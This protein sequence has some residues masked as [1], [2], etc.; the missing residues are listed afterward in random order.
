MFINVGRSF[1]L[2]LFKSSSHLMWRYCSQQISLAQRPAKREWASRVVAPFIQTWDYMRGPAASSSIYSAAWKSSAGGW[3]IGG[4]KA[5]AKWSPPQ[6]QLWRITLIHL[7]L[8][9]YIGGEKSV[10]H[11][12]E[13]WLHCPPQWELNDVMMT[14]GVNQPRLLRRQSGV[15]R[16]PCV[17]VF[18]SL[19]CRGQRSSN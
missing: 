10:C 6:W 7:N 18:S 13:C 3:R 16:P 1:W 5:T 12:D 8:G 15:C 17:C 4:G 19:T 14:C 9:C 11:W 2:H